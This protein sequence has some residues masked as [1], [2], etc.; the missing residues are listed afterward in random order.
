MPT[1]APTEITFAIG[2]GTNKTSPPT[3]NNDAVLGRQPAFRNEVRLASPCNANWKEMQGD[4]RVRLCLR[5]DK[6]V[7]NVSAMDKDAAE[8]LLRER[9]GTDMCVRFYQRADGTLLTQDCPKPVDSADGERAEPPAPVPT[10]RTT[11]SRR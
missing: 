11:T 4:E 2:L 3:S 7:Y 1:I 6:N 9:L 8:A 5:C 10:L